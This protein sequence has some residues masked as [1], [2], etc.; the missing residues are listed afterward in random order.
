MPRNRTVLL[1][2]CCVLLAAEASHAR[3]LRERIPHE[4]PARTRLGAHDDAHRVVLKFAEGT[5]LRSVASAARALREAG[6]PQRAIR[7]LFSRSALVLDA[8]RERGQRRSGRKLAD[9]NLYFELDAP[10]EI[11]TAALCDALN[12]L[13]FVELA[14]PARLPSLP[15]TDLPPETPDFAAGEGHRAPAPQG[16]GANIAARIQ[17]ATGNGIALVDIEYQWVLDHEDLELDPKTN[18]DKATLSDPF[19]SDEGNHG[20]AVLGILGARDNGYGVLGLVPDAT[21]LVAP[22]STVQH[23][24]DPARAVNLAAA[25]LAPGDVIL[26]EQQ[27]GA[28]GGSLGPLEAYPPWFDVIAHAT[29]QGIVVVEAAGNG[30]VDLDGAACKGWF[31]RSQRDSG[32]ILVGAGD[33]VDHSRL[34]FSTYGSRLDLQGW[35]S[36]VRTTGYWDLFAPGDI[37]QRYTSYFGGT[38]AA[39]PIVAAAGVA[40]QGA[41]VAHGEPPLEPTELR[42]LL[43]ATGT[44]QGGV[45][46]IGP[47]PDVPAALGV[48]GIQPPPMPGCGLTG[49]EC[50]PLLFLLRKLRRP[51]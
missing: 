36:S 12:A 50:I 42:A 33:P 23:G 29:A 22:A 35:G 51:V 32:A 3:A 21:L 20:T 19:P 13:P 11:D 24:Y 4:K 31:D 15:P 9:L 38:S 44:P 46:H 1:L 34:Y 17:G 28:C 47:L 10:A 49:I 27:T 7:R 41:L 16:I 48:L 37:R 6:L 40:V 2:A 39:A 18:I 14:L 8:E 30:A 25:Q 45:T 5:T 43:V 26:L